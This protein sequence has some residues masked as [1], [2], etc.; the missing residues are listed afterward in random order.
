MAAVEILRATHII[1]ERVRGVSKQV[2]VVD[3]RVA[4]VDDKIA[5]VINGAQITFSQA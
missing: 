3:D 2:L 4:S 1:D 5:E